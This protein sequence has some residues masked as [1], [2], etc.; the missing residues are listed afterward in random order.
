MN[1]YITKLL[2]ENHYLEFFVEG[3]RSRVGKM[4]SPK[5]GILSI[6]ARNVIEGKIPDAHILPV[7]INYEKVLE[8]QS[9][10]Y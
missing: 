10:T 3:T 8:G 7:T 6:V 4:L 1:E 5:F 9:F 2:V